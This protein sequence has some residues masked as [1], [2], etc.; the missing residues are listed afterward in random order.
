MC[1][2]NDTPEADCTPPD[3]LDARDGYGINPLAPA[4]PQSSRA[5]VMRGSH[6]VR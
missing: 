1:G 5:F 3:R 6:D 4:Y 2:I